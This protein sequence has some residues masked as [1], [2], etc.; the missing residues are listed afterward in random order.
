LTQVAAASRADAHREVVI[1]SPLRPGARNVGR[2]L[3]H[4]D[5]GGAQTLGRVLRR[6]LLATKSGRSPERSSS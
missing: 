5:P 1:Q 6:D 2:F 4:F 3:D